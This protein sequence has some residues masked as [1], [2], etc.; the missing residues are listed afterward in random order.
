MEMMKAITMKYI[1]LS[2]EEL[3]HYKTNPLEFFIHQK[4]D[5]GDEK[6]ILLRDKSKALISQISMRF[7]E[8]FKK[9]TTEICKELGTV[10]TE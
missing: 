10:T 3:E 4:D 9:F 5:A 8:A 1:I 6:G 7:G 2:Q